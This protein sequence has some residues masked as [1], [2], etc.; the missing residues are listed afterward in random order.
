MITLV[1]VVVLLLPL[2][3]LPLLVVLKRN[4]VT[5][6][7]T[8]LVTG[9]SPLILVPVPNTFEGTRHA[10]RIKNYPEK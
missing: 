1:E 2:L 6:K 10:S 7:H 9:I 8:N 3:L 5:H 4:T